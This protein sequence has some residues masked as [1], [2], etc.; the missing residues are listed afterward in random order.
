MRHHLFS[1]AIC[2]L[3]QSGASRC[4][5]SQA[6]GP[7]GLL[8]ALTTAPEGRVRPGGPLPIASC[9]QSSSSAPDRTY[10]S[11][12][13]LLGPVLFEHYLESYFEKE[14]KMDH[15]KLNHIDLD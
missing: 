2:C 5:V 12:P 9:A 11:N 15:T 10:K 6:L 3:L 13:I 7:H 1:D 14:V 4:Q 8:R